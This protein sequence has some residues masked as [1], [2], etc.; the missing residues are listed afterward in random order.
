MADVVLNYPAVN[1]LSAAYPLSC[2]T[3]AKKFFTYVVEDGLYRY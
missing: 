3:T 2:D 1:A